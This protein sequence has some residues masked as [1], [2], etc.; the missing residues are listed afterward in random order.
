MQHSKAER[1]DVGTR[2]RSALPAGRQLCIEV[3]DKGCGIEAARLP[4]LFEAFRSFDDRRASE[5]H[6]LGLGL[7]KAQA[8]PMGCELSV[9]SAPGCGSTF[10]LSGLSPAT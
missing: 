8:G 7:A 1:V 4:Q 3:R 9:R 2:W 10:T 5:S 6:G